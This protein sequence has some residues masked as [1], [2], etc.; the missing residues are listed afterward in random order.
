MLEISNAM[1]YILLN[2]YKIA[3]ICNYALNNV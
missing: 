2:N 3:K 1:I